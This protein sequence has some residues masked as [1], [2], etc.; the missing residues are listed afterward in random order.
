M[1]ATRKSYVRLGADLA[2]TRY[3]GTYSSVDLDSADSWGSLDFK[4]VPGGRGGLRLS[5]EIRD[6]ATLSERDNLAQA[7]ILRLLT[8]VGALGPLGHPAY[9]SRLV[10]LIGQL[11]NTTTRNLARLYTIAALD[12]EPRVRKLVDLQV[13]VVADQPDVIRIGFA[14]LPLDDDQPLALALELAL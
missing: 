8:P 4:V 9:G 11:N 6:L 10:E 5:G 14:V 13:S 12:A 3:T 7:L 2:L 1:A